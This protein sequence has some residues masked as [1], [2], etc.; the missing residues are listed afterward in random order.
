M[1][2][3][4]WE[5]YHYIYGD[6]CSDSYYGKEGKHKTIGYVVDTESNVKSLVDKLNAENHSYYAENVPEDEWD[7]DSV[8]EDYISYKELKIETLEEI[9][10]K[11][12]QY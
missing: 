5:I 10:Q 1:D 12:R 2:M 6:V 7:A 3:K 4:I 9:R 11:W 8:N